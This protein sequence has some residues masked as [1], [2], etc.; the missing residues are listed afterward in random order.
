MHVWSI[1]G[2]SRKK[3]VPL[4]KVIKRS[5]YF[6]DREIDLIKMDLEH[7]DRFLTF[8]DD[9]APIAR[10]NGSI[11]ELLEYLIPPQVSGKLSKPSGESMCY[12]DLVRFIECIFGITVNKPYDTKTRLLSRK[13]NVTPFLDKMRHTLLEE[14]NRM[15]M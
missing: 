8:P 7:P 11:A 13:K 2:T 14:V 10:W 1:C 6:V 5:M 12:S 3:N 4:Q 15:Y 9:R